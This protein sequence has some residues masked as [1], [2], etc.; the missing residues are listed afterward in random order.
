MNE[1]TEVERRRY[2]R[3]PATCPHDV[4][5]L[6]QQLHE[7]A[8][9]SRLLSKRMNEM[10]ECFNAHRDFILALKNRAE[11]KARFWRGIQ[12]R[13]LTAIMFTLVGGIFTVIWLGVQAWVKT[14]K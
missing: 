10:T 9:E 2:D 5:E 11:T 8:V 6:K 13:G 14:L 7:L 1:H 4:E 3:R 12:E